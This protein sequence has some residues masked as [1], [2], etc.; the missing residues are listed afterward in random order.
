MQEV[1]GIMNSF[2]KKQKPDYLFCPRCKRRFFFDAEE[3]FKAHLPYCEKPEE[4]P[5]TR[6]WD[7]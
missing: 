7:K 1:G 3:H 4:K 2:A 6:R 5:V